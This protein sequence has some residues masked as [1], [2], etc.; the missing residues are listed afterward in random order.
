MLNSKISYKIFDKTFPGTH[1]YA[2]YRFTDQFK[3][4]EIAANH[5]A[6]LEALAAKQLLI[7]KQVHGNTVID[8][9]S[10]TDYT[11]SP[12]ADAAVT[13]TP[14]LVLAIQSADC[15]PVLLADSQGNLVGAAHCGWRS[16]KDNILSNLVTMMRNKGAHDI[17]AIIGP[18]IHQESYEV[19][20]TFYQ[21]IIESE[22]NAIPLFISSA[23]KEHYIF[24]LPGFVTLKLHQ[25]AI[26]NIVNC[27]ENTYTNA[28]KYFSYR[29]DTHLGLA[30]NKTNLLSTIMINEFAPG[31]N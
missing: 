9:D 27:C 20:R 21:T 11:V 17:T 6:V 24:D 23:K 15:V 22:K 2:T 16:A 7:I 12:E 18:A 4:Q 14:G 10:L 13:T 25:L 3:L 29:R 28:Q 30:G 5:Q 1:L 8:A 19:D 26:T 31:N